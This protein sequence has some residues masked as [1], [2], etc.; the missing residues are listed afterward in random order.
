MEDEKPKVLVLH[1]NLEQELGQAPGK[2]GL[3]QNQRFLLRFFEFQFLRPRL[4]RQSRG[5]LVT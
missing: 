5:P 3:L 1:K 2:E 4:L